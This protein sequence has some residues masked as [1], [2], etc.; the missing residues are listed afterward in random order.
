MARDF[1]IEEKFNKLIKERF[2]DWKP[3]LIATD[4]Y[5]V[6]WGIKYGYH[7]PQRPFFV[8]SKQAANI[9]KSTMG[10]LEA[11]ALIPQKKFNNDLKKMI[12]FIGAPQFLA[13]QIVNNFKPDF[14]FNMARP[15]GFLV[16]DQI[17]FI[18][19]NTGTGVGGLDALHDFVTQFL[20]NPIV[21]ELKQDY[22]FTTM[23][24]IPLLANFFKKDIFKDKL[25]GYPDYD[26][27]EPKTG[28]HSSDG[29]YIATLMQRN[30]VP[31]HIFFID[32]AEVG[33]RGVKVKDKEFEVIFKNYMSNWF[34]TLAEP[35][36]K[37]LE[38]CGKNNVMMVDS[39]YDKVLGDKMLLPLLSDTDENGFLPEHLKT[40]CAASLPWTRFVKDYQTNYLNQKVS[41]CD[42]LQKRKNHLFIKKGTGFQA[43]D[44]YC[45]ADMSNEEWTQKVK[46]AL[47]EK[48]WIV[49]EKVESKKTS[50]PFY[51]N[52][53]LEF[54]DVSCVVSPFVVDKQMGGMMI[55]TS[56]PNSGNVFNLR[57]DETAIAGST[58]AVIYDPAD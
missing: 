40:I 13:P 1:S 12:E 58:A 7:L 39:P 5:C 35:H 2:E 3:F 10:F 26:F 54:V 8:S 57:T 44:V 11:V 38:A 52:E 43:Q 51:V 24:P 41:L 9:E 46:I 36:A 37:L 34:F 42:V 18:E 16:D 32:E 47:E 56:L 50:M 15:D 55:S 17:L 27:S 53:K 33:S 21:G 31:M 14:S 30:N 28:K 45:G 25:I 49:Q 4:E 19:Q 6:K 23:N 20:K 29:E 22:R 48:N